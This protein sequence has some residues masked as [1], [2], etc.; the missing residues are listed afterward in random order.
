M[1]A[2]QGSLHLNEKPNVCH[3]CRNVIRKATPLRRRRRGLHAPSLDE[4]N[5]EGALSLYWKLINTLHLV[6]YGPHRASCIVHC[7]KGKCCCMRHRHCT[8]LHYLLGRM[9]RGLDFTVMIWHT[10][11]HSMHTE[12]GV[13]WLGPW[14]CCMPH[15]E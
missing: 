8:P 6:L 4:N 9:K 15:F 14:V 2:L 12:A 11:R 5:G 7:C 13:L 3:S 10:G 1:E